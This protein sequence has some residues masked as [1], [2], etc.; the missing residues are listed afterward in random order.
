MATPGRQVAGALAAALLAAG[1]ARATAPI[2]TEQDAARAR[3]RWPGVTVDELARGRALLVES[4]GGCHLVPMPR[5]HAPE[6]WPAL[7]DEM[8]E[9][10]GLD[11]AQ[12][13]ALTRYLV[14]MAAAPPAP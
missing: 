10:S 2:A 13:D 6:A 11:A 1:C 12:G 3:A 14:T 5:E 7:V 4:C 9:R 8:R